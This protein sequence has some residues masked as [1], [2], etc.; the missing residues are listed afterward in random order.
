MGDHRQLDGNYELISIEDYI[1]VQIDIFLVYLI[2][3]LQDKKL[4]THT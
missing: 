4:L 3:S 2:I 1:S